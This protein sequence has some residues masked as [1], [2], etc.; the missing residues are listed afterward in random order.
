MPDLGAMHARTPRLRRR[1]QEASRRLGAH[2]ARLASEPAK[3]CQ[4]G[5]DVATRLR[6]DQDLSPEA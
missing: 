1:S 3:I 2:R 5:T 4:A 6:T